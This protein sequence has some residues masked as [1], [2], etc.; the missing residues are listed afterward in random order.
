MG[1]EALSIADVPFSVTTQIQR[2]P[3]WTM[4]REL[5]MNALEAASTSTGEKIVHWTSRQIDGVRKAVIWNTGPG[6]DAGQ[7]K[8]AT[9]LACRLDKSLGID[10]NFGVGAKVSSL[11]NNHNGMRFRSCKYGKVSEVIL[12]Y[13]PDL[14]QYVRFERTLS[15]G[16]KDTVI[17]VTTLAQ[18]DGHDLKGEWTEVTLFGNSDEQDTA[19]KPLASTQTDKGYVATALYRRFYRFPEGV[20]LKLDDVYQRLGNTRS[21]V[22]M[23]ERYDKFARFESVR[24]EALNATIHFLHDPP[25]GDKSGLRTSSRGA[26]GSTTTTCGLVHK[27]E[28]YSVMTGNEWSAAAP[29]FGIPFGSKELCIHIELDDDEARASGYRERLISKE[30]AVDIVPQDYAFCVREVMPDWVKEVILNASPRKT[31]DFKD[32]QKEL[33]DL[34]NKFKVR[35]AGRKIDVENGKPTDDEKG[36]DPSFGGG[37]I[38]GDKEG[39]SSRR[40][41]RR[42]QEAPE[43]AITTSLYEVFE[44]PPNIIMLDK[45]EEV[46]EKALKSRAGMFI[47]ETGDLFV[48]GLYEAVTR[49]VDDIEP[50]FAGQGDAETV[51]TLITNAARR[52]LAFR[53]GKAVV[54]ALAKRANEDWD[55]TALTTAITKESLTIA[56]D[57]Y[58]EGLSSVRREVKE[59]IKVSRIAA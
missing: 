23:G 55:H 16:S 52:Q 20:K 57:N 50:D 53:V 43:G 36:P 8:K 14:K 42:F 24:V 13:D 58:L 10:E 25:V 32:I 28:M 3:H 54:F 41:T 26:L 9:D 5:T 2:A 45:I 11:A 59:G 37:G 18:Q 12:G 1:N 4:I 21:L 48:N 15:N 51:R 30:A 35:V 47:L 49:T 56:A 17:D 6:M 29:H 7:L 39:S 22:P 40:G 31:E 38:G 44:K 33:Q 19:A 27:D 34:L 46:E